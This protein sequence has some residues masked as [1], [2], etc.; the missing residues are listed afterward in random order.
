MADSSSSTE[1]LRT[2][3]ISR[4][5]RVS[6][7]T[8]RRWCQRGLLPGVLIDS[9]WRVSPATIA[10]LRQA[11]ALAYLR[12][13]AKASTHPSSSEGKRSLP[14]RV[15]PGRGVA[16]APRAHGTTISPHK[17]K[18]GL[19]SQPVDNKGISAG[20]SEGLTVLEIQGVT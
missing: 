8:V 6:S 9:H 18:K 10:A 11:Q 12:F 13:V 15:T 20:T 3:A 14:G 1:L 19:D 7:R 17:K 4:E 16:D 2:G 5:L